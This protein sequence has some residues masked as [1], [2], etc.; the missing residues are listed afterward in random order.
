M[1][2]LFILLGPRNIDFGQHPALNS[3]YVNA[4]PHRMV[5]GWNCLGSEEERALKEEGKRVRGEKEEEEGRGNTH[6]CLN[7][8][9]V[10]RLSF[11]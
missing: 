11:C 8:S 4:L 7:K 9:Q 1:N 2:T 3:S 5:R 10:S 6:L